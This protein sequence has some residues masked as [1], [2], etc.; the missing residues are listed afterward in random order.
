MLTKTNNVVWERDCC[1]K[2]LQAKG[3]FDRATSYEGSMV[4]YKGSHQFW[5]PCV[6]RG[7]VHWEK[8]V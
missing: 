1:M 5:C 3:K 6:L 2:Y 4:M 7:E 8:L